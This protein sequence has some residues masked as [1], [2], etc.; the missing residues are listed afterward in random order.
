MKRQN[1]RILLILTGVFWGLGFVGNKLILN[2]NLTDQ[3]LLFFRFL[4]ATIGLLIYIIIKT[5]RIKIISLKKGAFL[6]IFLY[7]GFSF[8]TWGL[9]HT[10]ASNN[11]IITASYI[12]I[13]PLIMNAVF[14]HKFSWKHIVAVIFTLFGVIFV[15]FD[16]ESV[17]I[18]FGD[19]LTLIGAFFFAIHIIFTERFVKNENVFHLSLFQFVVIT[20]L[21]GLFILFQKDTS[22][23]NFT[24]GGI[25]IMLGLGLISSLL[26]FLFQ[27]IGQKY[28]KSHEAAILISTESVFGP[29][30]AV[31]ILAEVVST[32]YVIGFI[33]IIGGI[34]I[35]EYSSDLV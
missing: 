11:A 4:V 3:T 20:F 27:T 18:S 35:S 14:K 22:Y 7:L 16:F 9:I 28:T 5:P 25:L 6:G 8:Q 19:I 2:L 26:A 17:S 31:L 12:A 13:V 33:L 23:E 10:T 24:S 30:F 1:A 32:F 21:A 29:L 34:I 15:S